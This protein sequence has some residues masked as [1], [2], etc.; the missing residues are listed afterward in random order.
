MVIN[1]KC[2]WFKAFIINDYNDSDFVYVINNNAVIVTAHQHKETRKEL[3]QK[4][5]AVVNCV[6]KC[7]GILRC[8]KIMLRLNLNI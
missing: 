8:I 1:L 4:Y 7:R 5:F 2:L 3:F 6:S